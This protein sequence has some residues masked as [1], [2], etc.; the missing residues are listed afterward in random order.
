M[1]TLLLILC[2]LGLQV[3]HAQVLPTDTVPAV[4]KFTTENGAT[5]F[6]SELRP[7]RQIA[8]APAPFYTYFWEF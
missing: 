7:L 6:D 1:K 3:V 4:I 5:K 8:G 2:C